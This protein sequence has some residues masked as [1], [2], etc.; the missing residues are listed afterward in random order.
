MSSGFK[1]YPLCSGCF[2]TVGPLVWGTILEATRGPSNHN[3]LQWA[4]GAGRKEQSLGKE[5][6]PYTKVKILCFVITWD[7]CGV[8]LKWNLA[9]DPMMFKLCSRTELILTKEFQGKHLNRIM[10]NWVIILVVTECIFLMALLSNSWHTINYR[11]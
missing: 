11:I 6:L 1:V 9:K 8:L 5:K 10:K 3:M 7:E 2:P 4:R